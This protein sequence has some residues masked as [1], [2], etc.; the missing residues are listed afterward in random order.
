MMKKV[1]LIMVALVSM[2]SAQRPAITDFQHSGFSSTSAQ[3]W[4]VL[5]GTAIDS[6]NSIS[7]SLN[8]TTEISWAFSLDS[9][10]CQI[11]GYYRIAGSWAQPETLTTITYA[12][13]ITHFGKQTTGVGGILTVG[14]KYSY[15]KGNS[16]SMV[17]RRAGTGYTAQ[18]L[19]ANGD[20]T[21][22]DTTSYLIY[23]DTTNVKVRAH[24]SSPWATRINA[25]TPTKVGIEAIRIIINFI[26]GTGKEGTYVV[27]TKEY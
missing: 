8:A 7:T 2:A 1:F 10:K 24:T 14:T 23:G 12:D 17:I 27:K 13:S 11:L 3:R 26:A 20:L 21:V 15:T 4:S 22:T 16:D 18:K 6:S 9:I 19:T 25:V 5:R